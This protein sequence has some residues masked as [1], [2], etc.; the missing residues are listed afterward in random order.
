MS[1]LN[2]QML[3]DA[4][5]PQ[6]PWSFMENIVTAKEKAACKSQPVAITGK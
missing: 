1:K 5:C 2:L 6:P 4:E 3:Y